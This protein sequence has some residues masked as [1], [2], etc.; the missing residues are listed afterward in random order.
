MRTGCFRVEEGV[1]YYQR[2]L[3]LVNKKI[4]EWKMT[5]RRGSGFAF[6]TFKTKAGMSVY[7]VSELPDATRCIVDARNK[8]LAN[9][10]KQLESESWKVSQA[11]EAR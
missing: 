9:L 2:K 6:V 3:S 8:K 10:S 1:P 4:E 7:V 11:Q 5:Q